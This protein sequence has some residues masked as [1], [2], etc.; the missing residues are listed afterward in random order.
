MTVMEVVGEGS[1]LRIDKAIFLEKDSSLNDSNMN[2]FL[3][4]LRNYSLV[5][6]FKDRCSNDDVRNIV[7]ENKIDLRSIDDDVQIDVKITDSR[8][9]TSKHLYGITDFGFMLDMSIEKGIIAMS[10][11]SSIVIFLIEQDIIYDLIH[12]VDNYIH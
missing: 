5:I 7:I 8:N 4:D 6:S 2:I 9:N 10:D 11:N 1:V 12:D 3:R